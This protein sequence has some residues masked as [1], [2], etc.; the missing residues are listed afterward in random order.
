LE[1]GLGGSEALVSDGDDL[2]VGQLV[3]LLDLGGVGSSVHLSVEVK[4]DVAELLLDVKGASVSKTGCSS[5]A[6]R[7]SL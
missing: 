7:S 4:S 2:T 6:T 1:E 5:G 3:G